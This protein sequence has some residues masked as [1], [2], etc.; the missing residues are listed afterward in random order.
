LNAEGTK[1]QGGGPFSASTIYGNRRRGTGVLNNELYI[2][3]QIW[4]KQSFRKDPDTGRENGRLNDESTW[5]RTEVPHLRIISDELWAKVKAYQKALDER[6]PTSAH[7]KRPERLFSFLLKCGECGGGYS[8]VSASQYGCS[9]ARNKGT[10]TNRLTISEKR[11]EEAVL[12][13]LRQRLMDPKLCKVFCEEY[14]AHINRIRRGQS[15]EKSNAT[16]RLGRVEQEIAKMIQAIK[17][18]VDPVLIRDE[19]NDLQRQKV[20]LQATIDAKHEAPVF[21][22]PNMARRYSEQIQSLISNMNHPEYRK[23]S[24]QI[25]RRLIERIVLSPNEDSSALTVDLY[26]DLAGI[27]R[28]SCGM[29]GGHIINPPGMLSSAEFSELQQIRLLVEESDDPHDPNDGTRRKS[30]LGRKDSNLRMA[31]PKTAALPLGYAPARAALYSGSIGDVK[32]AKARNRRP[33]GRLRRERW[34]PAACLRSRLGSGVRA[35]GC[36]HRPTPC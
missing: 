6:G 3:M 14:T 9:A 27:L 23:D 26:G 21:V 34:S 36:L 32:G 1:A 10:C 5:I 8:K 28:T 15:S 4:G 12:G 18:G 31:V 25:V 29:T 11:L 13:S 17:N 24:A 35:A 22:H 33:L 30:W 7:K 20:A 2:G 19:I 16:D